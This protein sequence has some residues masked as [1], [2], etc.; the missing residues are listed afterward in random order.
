[1]LFV[2]SKTRCNW[3]VTHVQSVSDN[4]RIEPDPYTID[5]RISPRVS[6]CTTWNQ[7]DETLSVQ[8]THQSLI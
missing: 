5:F 4:S 7:R 8:R 2:V 6:W 3:L 1:M